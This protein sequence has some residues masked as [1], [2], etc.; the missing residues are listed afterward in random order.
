[1]PYR[2]DPTHPLGWV[3]VPPGTPESAGTVRYADAVDHAGPAVLPD[4]GD[5]VSTTAPDP[6]PDEVTDPHDPDWVAPW[7]D[8]VHIHVSDGT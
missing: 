1:M 4:I 5:H 6:T 2:L 7:T 3:Y 8:Q